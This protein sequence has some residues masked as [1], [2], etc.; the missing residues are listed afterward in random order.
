MQDKRIPTLDLFSGIG[1]NALALRSICKVV[2]YCDSWKYSRAVLKTLMRSG[3][4]DTAHIYKD[5]NTLKGS[6]LSPKPIMITA[7]FP[8]QDAACSNPRG[9][10]VFGPRTGLFFEI[11]RLVDELPSIKYLLLE[12]S[13]CIAYAGRGLDRIVAELN[14][15]GF[16]MSM[17]VF[18][19]WEELG[20]PHDRKRWICLACRG[21]PH[22]YFKTIRCKKFSKWASQQ[23]P[24]PRLVDGPPSAK[25]I[26]LKRCAL[27][28]NSVVPQQISMAVSE[29]SSVG[30]HADTSCTGN[31][32]RNSIV[33]K[34][35]NVKVATQHCKQE[36]GE[37]RDYNLKVG[38]IVY[39]KWSSP[40]HKN[41][42]AQRVLTPRVTRQLCVQ[43]FKE[44]GTVVP[45][46]TAFI[47]PHFIE[48]MMGFP[49]E[50]TLFDSSFLDD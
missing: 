18:G 43:L 15:R 23:E 13:S 29:L 21:P 8:C 36:R 30:R 25:G 35:K 24:V 5:V 39:K 42:S 38:S 40:T 20:A 17:S 41:W 12:N 27:L 50:W 7:G 32:L 33:H 19:T 4:L 10:G 48:Y 37:G 49:K 44:K 22:P 2:A 45:S 28:G 1:G 9:K 46:A 47:N 26:A 14:K 34:G 16:D 3:K 11:M 6:D 31:I